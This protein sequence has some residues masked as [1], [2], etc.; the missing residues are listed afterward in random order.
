MSI[1]I[2]K[3]AILYIV[4]SNY[5]FLLRFSII[6]FPKQNLRRKTMAKSDLLKEAIADAK[7]VKET[8]L[9]NAKIAL[10]EAFAPRLERMLATKLTNEIEGE[11]EEMP[12][13]AE[14][15]D[16]EPEMDAEMDVEAGAGNDVG[17]LSIDVDGDG[18][19]DEFDI[20]SQEGGEEM[21]EEMPEEEPAM[22]DEEMTDEYNEGY[23]DRDLDLE[24]IIR[25]LEGDLESEEP[26]LEDEMAMEGEH[27]G[28]DHEDEMPEEDELSMDSIDEILEAILREEEMEEEPEMTTEGEDSEK[29]EMKAELEEAYATVKHLQGILSEVNLLN[30]KLLYTNKLFRNF[31]LSEAQKMKVIENFDRAGNTREVKLVFTTLAESFNRPTK[32]RVVKESYASKAAASTAPS[33]ESTQVLSEG[34]ELANRWKKLAGLL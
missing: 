19:F 30:A 12:V 24:S 34:F 23:D 18:E 31:E 32:K 4:S 7:A 33:K 27:M 14:P 8:A 6:L 25:E 5:Y 29:E 11:E 17:D 9:A 3:Y 15:V 16:A 22:S 28:M 13:D 1:F 2:E 21:P 20:Y 10:Q 26:N